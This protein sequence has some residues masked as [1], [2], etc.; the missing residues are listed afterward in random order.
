MDFKVGEDDCDCYPAE[1]AAEPWDVG[2]WWESM[3]DI[4]W[5][6]IFIDF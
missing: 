6:T 3:V 2:N 1:Y 4:L 5:I